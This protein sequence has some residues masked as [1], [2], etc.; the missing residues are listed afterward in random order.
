VVKRRVKIEKIHEMIIK[1]ERLY[2]N[3]KI[4]TQKVYMDANMA[5]KLE[6]ISYLESRSK[7]EISRKA[8]KSFIN[9]YESKNGNLLNK[10]KR[11]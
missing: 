1:L 9:A 4:Y 6:I 5:C 10:I 11:H 7:S 3:N 2:N 8:I